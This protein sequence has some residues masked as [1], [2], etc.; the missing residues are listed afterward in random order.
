MKELDSLLAPH[1][2][3]RRKSSWNRA[4][5]PRIDIIQLQKSKSGRQ[6]TINAGVLDC[7]VYETVWGKPIGPLADESY[8]TV[9]TRVGELISGHDVW[10]DI[11]DPET[12]TQIRDAVETKILPFLEELRTKEQLEH[13]LNSS[14]ALTD[15]YPLPAI[16]LAVLRHQ[17]GDPRGAAAVLESLRGRVNDAW[18]TRLDA[19][20]SQLEPPTHP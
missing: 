17:L 11:S 9:R 10:W 18:N 8:A 7:D 12:P 6:L 20:S 2:F 13:A 4:S 5:G 3:H 15:P 14:G 16:N 1:G 19:I